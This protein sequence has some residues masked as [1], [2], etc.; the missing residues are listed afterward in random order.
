LNSFLVL[1]QWVFL[2]WRG[3]GVAV[4]ILVGVALA[5]LASEGFYPGSLR[6]AVSTHVLGFVG[7]PFAAARQALFDSYQQVMPRQRTTQPVTLVEI[8]ER[9][10]KEMGQWPWPRNKLALLVDKIAASQPLAI[11]LDM[12]MPEVDQTSPGLVAD[13]LPAGHADLAAALKQLESHDDRLVKSLKAAPTVLGAAAFNQQT[14]T[15]GTGLLSVPINTRGPDALPHLTHFQWILA[16][17]PELQA[18]ARGQAVLSVDA[19]QTVVRRSPLVMAVNDQIVPSLAVEMLRVAT[20][21]PAIEVTVNQHGVAG[22]TV[23]DLSIPSQPN[24]E[25]WLHFANRSDTDLAR[26]VSASA[27]LDGRVTA[28]AFTN[29]L[30]LLG[31]TGSGLNDRRNTPL[32]QLVPGVE[33]QAQLLESF[34]EGRF[35][36]RPWWMKGA[37]IAVLVAMGLLMVWLIPQ[38]RQTVANEGRAKLPKASGWLLLGG[39][40]S[41]LIAGFVLFARAGLLFDASTVV[42]GYAL[43]L[44]SLVSSSMLETERD[45]QHL[46]LAEQQ[47]REESARVAGELAAARHIQLGSL[48]DAAKAFPNEQR[49][50]FATLLEPAREVGGDLYDFFRVDDEHLCFVVADV[51][52]KGVPASVFMA[53]TKTLAK[54]FSL[55]LAGGPAAV[56]R[57]ANQDL[58]RENAGALFV[59]L[60]LGVLNVRS[61]Q[62]EL[63]NAGHDSPWRISRNGAVEKIATPPETGGPPLCVLDDFAY[64]S[65]QVQLAPGDTLCLITD[66]VTEAVN[67]KNELFGGARLH[68]ALAALPVGQ[69]LNAAMQQVRAEIAQFVDGAEASDDLTL[70]LLRWHPVPEGQASRL[71]SA[72]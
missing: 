34:L 45:N 3:R 36:L 50:E 2:A 27:V 33:I 57:A 19:G 63:V 18:A 72:G 8:D 35:L 52:G 30:V 37:E 64:V 47:L 21:E 67:G 51:S 11:G 46:A 7:T 15:S 43:V 17:L 53:M 10:L 25:V 24:G 41:L 56:V 32:G 29:K 69:S 22:V 1:L 48:P 68:A 13:N 60:L 39:C 31:L 59:T 71:P 23:A 28:E 65:Q 61:G 12:Y 14:Q 16:S 70:L 62:L 26:Q 66:G 44:V 42:M 55:R 6:G 58:A 38:S 40:A 9:S 20:G 54:S 4:C 49:F 5:S